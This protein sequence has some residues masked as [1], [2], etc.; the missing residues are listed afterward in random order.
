[1]EEKSDSP[2]LLDTLAAAYAE[3]GRFDEALTSARRALVLA[4]AAERA[5]LAAALESRIARY[6]SGAP[7]PV[8]SR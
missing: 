8:E 1:M 3:A 4:N 5:E 7:Y 6:A 2:D